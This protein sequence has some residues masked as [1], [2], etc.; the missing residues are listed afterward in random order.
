MCTKKIAINEST[1]ASSALPSLPVFCELVQ[2]ASEKFEFNLLC[3]S[4]RRNTIGSKCVEEMQEVRGL[5]DGIFL[6][7]QQL[8]PTFLY[9]FYVTFLTFFHFASSLPAYFVFLI[10]ITLFAHTYTREENVMLGK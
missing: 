8:V 7:N 1:Q 9:T 2:L 3:I 10:I 5:N 4:S 6:H